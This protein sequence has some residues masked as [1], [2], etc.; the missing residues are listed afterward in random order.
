MVNIKKPDWLNKNEYPFESHWFKTSKGDIHYIDEGKGEPLVFV[1]GNPSWSFEYRNLIKELSI[2]HRCIAIDHL[3]FGLSDKPIDWSYLPTDHAENLENLLNFLKLK[4][5]TLIVG[6]WGGPI[7]LSYAIKYPEKIKNVVITNTWLWSV[8]N[9]LYYQAFSKFTG[10]PIGRFL[11]RKHNFFVKNIF[12]ALFGD[13]RKLTQEIHNHYLLP[14]NKSEERKGNWTFP[15]QI[16][17]S[18]DWLNELWNKVEVLKLK[19]ILIAWGMKDPGFRKKELDK[20]IKVFSHAKVI[21][22]SDVG[23]FVAEEKSAELASEIKSYL[24]E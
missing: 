21:C 9:D 1:H 17:E 22:F 11:I 8:K 5:I 18:S 4:E 2:S 23:H 7:G 3:G 15:K 19:K 6:D 12:I 13:K 10:G 16:I 24:V 20:W 14:L